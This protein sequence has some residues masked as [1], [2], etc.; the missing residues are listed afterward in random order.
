MKRKYLFLPPHSSRLNF[1]CDSSTS[2]LQSDT[3]VTGNGG[4]CQ[5][6]TLCLWHSFLFTLFP[7]SSVWSLPWETVIHELLQHKSFPWA[8]VI[9]GLFQH[10]S[11]LLGTVLQERSSPVW[12]LYRVTGPAIKPPACTP[13]HRPQFL[14]G[15]CSSMDSLCAAQLFHL[16]W[17]PLQSVVWISAP[18]WS[19]PWTAGNSAPVLELLFILVINQP[20]PS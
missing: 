9:Q 7:Y 5:F 13:L 2:S 20:P 19:S 17:C 6:I 4:C 10:G 3:Q 18:L 16:L 15:A 14:P 8:A 11:F 1:I 12:V